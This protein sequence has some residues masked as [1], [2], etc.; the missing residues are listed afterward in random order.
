LGRGQHD[1]R[2]YHSLTYLLGFFKALMAAL[3]FVA[4]ILLLWIIQPQL[5]ISQLSG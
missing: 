4:A 5:A 3:F 1:R 2:F